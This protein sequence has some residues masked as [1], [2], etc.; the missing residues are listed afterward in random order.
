MLL[1][2]LAGLGLLEGSD[3]KAILEVLEF[4]GV[5]CREEVGVVDDLHR[6]ELN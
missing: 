6:K 4:V 5:S 2:A 3:V 1:C